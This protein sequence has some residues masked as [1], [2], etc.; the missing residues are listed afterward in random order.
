V[1]GHDAALVALAEALLAHEDD[2]FVVLRALRSPD[3]SVADFV[4]EL[5]NAAAE[6]NA[7]RPLLGRRQLELYPAGPGSIFEALR[8]VLVT[9]APLHQQL[10]V[11]GDGD[12]A[13]AGH[14][15]EF[16]A[17]QAEGDRVVCWYRD[18]TAVQAAQRALMEQALQD[19][20]TGLP[21]RRLLLDHAELALARL[22]R[23][24]GVVALLF[25]D[26]DGFKAV[27]DSLGHPAG[28]ELLRQVAERL[29]GAVRPE[30]TVARFGGD[31]F[32]VLCEG[33]VGEV[34]PGA[35]AR[36]LREA[37]VG[38]YD[39]LGGP[40]SVGMSV[41]VATTDRVV[42]VERLLTEA[43]TALYAAKRTVGRP[44]V[45]AG[46]RGQPG[47]PDNQSG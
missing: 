2:A 15:Y 46:E 5:V 10:Q 27:N 35:M 3:G 7:G 13:T 37:V 45:V 28:D 11:P 30:D 20:L 8:D 34:H 41:G 23:H 47:E 4:H 12:P 42:P 39:V 18:V 31:E 26:L 32:V 21:N 25:C 44:I 17:R 6:R 29:R 9:G 43:D 19:P 40:V 16:Y 14:S 38:R 1:T 36:R 24:R 33:G 22:P